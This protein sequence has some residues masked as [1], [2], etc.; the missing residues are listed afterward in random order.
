MLGIAGLVAAILAP[1]SADATRALWTV[2]APGLAAWAVMS[3]CYLPV[4][5]LYRLHSWRAP[6]LPGVMA[7]YAAM[8]LD[9]ARRHRQ[10][11]G[12]SWKGRLIQQ[13]D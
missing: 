4:L 8:T 6:L 12:G 9:S 3:A 1:D 5:R 10:G 13:E 2:A 7:L 11:K